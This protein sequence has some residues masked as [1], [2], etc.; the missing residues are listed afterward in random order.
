MSAG[1][2]TRGRSV[3]A[4]VRLCITFRV[5]VA[6]DGRRELSLKRAHEEYAFADF[7]ALPACSN[8]SARARVYGTP[9]EKHLTRIGR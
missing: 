8:T 1:E 5:R 7:Y 6:V 3:R 9:G 4:Q 2:R